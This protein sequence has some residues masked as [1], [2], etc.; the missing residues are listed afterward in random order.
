MILVVAS[1]PRGF[2]TKILHLT[3]D[4]GGISD[5]LRSY[6][7]RRLTKVIAGTKGR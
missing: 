1:Q 6:P 3:T 4:D 5:D 7:E 2:P